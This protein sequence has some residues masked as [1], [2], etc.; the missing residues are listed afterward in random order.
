MAS[1]DIEYCGM[2][3]FLLVARYCMVV[4]VADVSHVAQICRIPIELMGGKLTEPTSGI[5]TDAQQG[6]INSQNLILL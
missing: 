3:M 1:C 5:R 6:S 4:L 2:D